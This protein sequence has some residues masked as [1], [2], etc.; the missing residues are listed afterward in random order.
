MDVTRVPSFESDL[1]CCVDSDGA[2]GA[3]ASYISESDHSD[4]DMLPKLKPELTPSTVPVCN[5]GEVINTSSCCPNEGVKA[6]AQQSQGILP[7]ANISSIHEL[8]SNA[9]ENPQVESFPE[10][11]RD[12]L[13]IVE[14]Q[15][16]L[17]MA[18][19]AIPH[20]EASS[21]VGEVAEMGRT[22]S[23]SSKKRKRTLIKLKDLEEHSPI[24][25]LDHIPP[26]QL[27][28][29]PRDISRG[30]EKVPI[31]LCKD[32]ARAKDLP[33]DFSYINASVVYQSAHVGISMARIGED[34]RCSGC[35]GNCLDNRVPCEC[36]RLTDGEYA[37]TVEGCL[38]PHFLKQELERKRDLN[39][40]S[41]C[42][43]GACPVERTNDEVCK[44][45]VQR[46]FIK[47]CWEKCG[48]TQLCGN[49]I[50]QRGVVHR[51]QVRLVCNVV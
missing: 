18:S 12:A 20:E 39:L 21:E 51:L 19:T 38:Y 25:G 50:V 42:Q 31:S 45:H 23:E 30:K 8:Q 14:V 40:L 36:T 44:G 16:T 47:E 28:H 6:D 32:P 41:Y 7:L 26:R 49:R 11:S 43:P 3:L 1:C 33:A 35:V 17:P 4:V 48:C 29:D 46:R 15:Q 13:V 9:F 24:H 2:L 37:Y 5:V 10:Q 27:R 34:D 22:S